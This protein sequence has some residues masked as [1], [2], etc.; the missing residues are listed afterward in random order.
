NKHLR[1]ISST[2]LLEQAK[3]AL[4]MAMGTPYKEFDEVK[5]SAEHSPTFGAVSSSPDQLN[6]DWVAEALEQRADLKAI[7]LRQE[8]NHILLAKY[9]RDLL[10]QV[11]VTLN[12]GY[13]GLSEGGRA[14]TFGDSLYRNVPGPNVSGQLTFSYPLENNTQEGLL[15]RQKAVT[16]NTEIGMGQLQRT[17]SAQVD[18]DVS[19]LT[20]RMAEKTMAE[21]A[22]A[23]YQPAV[24]E[25]AERA[26]KSAPMMLNLLEYE[27]RLVAAKINR[28]QVES[29]LAK[30][31]AEVRFQT[32]TL[33]VGNDETLAVNLES[34][35][36]F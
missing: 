2:Q 28:L 27:D 31:I 6:K 9:N 25:L 3:I 32:G 17:I 10:P 26:M 24:N 20:R 4:S 13:Q 16:R 7:N 36:R 21:K 18:V 8:A 29:A 1:V 34:L 12:A 14:T 11:D 33:I 35:Q 5:V 22:V 15:A 19:L 23:F 30:L